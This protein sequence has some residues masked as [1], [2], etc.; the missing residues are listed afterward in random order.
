MA[1]QEAAF[2]VLYFSFSGHTEDLARSIAERLR[3][4]L[5]RFEAPRY[6]PG[7][8]GYMRAGYDSLRQSRPEIRVPKVDF[9]R[10]HAV[11]IG[12]PI[13]TSYPSAP[14]RSLFDNPP[15]LP[16]PLGL[17]LSCDDHSPPQKAY[18]LAEAALRL[19]FAARM[20][21]PSK[22][23]GTAE[24]ARRVEAFCSDMTFAARIPQPA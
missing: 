5:F 2:A 24:M 19:H 7:F 16:E 23:N 11:A 6:T 22:D 14:L 4:D 9:T 20:Y 10:Y 17:F 21:L 3:A 8:L 12:G 13:W 18:D 1:V 15:A